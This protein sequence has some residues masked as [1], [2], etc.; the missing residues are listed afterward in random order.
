MRINRLSLVIPALLTRI[1]IEPYS[2]TMFR[3]IDLKSSLLDI[4]HENAV[5]LPPFSVIFLIV[6]SSASLFRAKQ[7]TVAP[8]FAISI[9]IV[10][11]MP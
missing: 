6:V 1:S 4:S 2:L 8:D 10:S 7:N 5:A 11:P 3:I 9:A